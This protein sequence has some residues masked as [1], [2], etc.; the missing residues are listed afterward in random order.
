MGV[1]T[2]IA[3]TDSTFQPWLGC[4]RVSPACDHCYAAALAKRTG[5]RDRAGLD[6]WDPHADRVR[7]SPDYWTRP[8]RWNREALAAG[9][10]RRVF[11]ASMADIFDNRAPQAWREDLWA[12][13]RTTPALDWQ[14]LTKRPQNAAKMLPSDWGNGWPNVWL[15]TTTENQLE[16]A[17]RIPEL[18][19]LPAKVHFLSV[20]PMLKAVELGPW[21]DGLQWII[22]GGESGAGARP[23]WPSWV[24]QLRDQVQAAGVAL[25]FKQVGSNRAL[26]PGV[27]GKG[28]D[29]AEWPE[30]LRIREFP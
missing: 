8:H 9:E 12:L 5:R 16:A 18:L 4:L 7:T 6:L 2:A 19:A 30:D 27:T 25:F 28:E 13:I 17:R 15:G 24:R 23:M 11:C 26:W 29:P 3:W 22:V 10:R 20:E 14:I 1:T 21:L